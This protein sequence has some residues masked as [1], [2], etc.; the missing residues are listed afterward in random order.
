MGKGKTRRFIPAIPDED[1][2]SLNNLRKEHKLSWEQVFERF[3]M[4][5]GGVEYIFT[6]PG[7]LT[8]QTRLDLNT[9]MGLI[10]TWISNISHNWYEIHNTPDISVLKKA[11]TYAGRPAICIGA[12]PSLFDHEH[13]D[14]LAESSFQDKG[15]VIFSTAHSLKWCLDAGIVP[16]IVNVVD[17]DQKMVDFISGAPEGD[18]LDVNEVVDTIKLV[19]IAS[20]HPEV[21]NRWEGKQK[22]TFMSGVP[23]SIIPN[24]DTFL[25]VLLPELT[26]LDT[27]GNS[28]TCN[29]SLAAYL[30]CGPI[31]LVGMDFSYPKNYPYDQTQ[32]YNAYLRSVGLEYRD[33]QEMIEKC[34]TDYVHPVYET[35]CYY[36]FVYE[37]FMNGLLELS[38]TYE[39]VWGT[40]LINCTEGGAIH[41]DNIECI[42]L[43]EFIER[44]TV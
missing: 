40:K 28:G 37:V 30:G 10:N 2:H 16:D 38:K 27:G 8:K 6:A 39:Q 12:G 44:Y 34:Y 25:S 33:V 23:Q 14:L 29:F 11:G 26:Q 36:D 13:L 3:R 5:S 7:K 42:G 21:L 18:G 19:Y 22:Y 4:Y 35:E 9:V 17:G 15:G 20:T 43:G 41:A 1:W 32:Y 24:V 31:G